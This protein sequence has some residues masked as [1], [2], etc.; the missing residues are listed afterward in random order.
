MDWVG[1]TNPLAPL[2]PQYN[3][4]EFLFWGYVKDQILCPKVGV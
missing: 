1:Q 4:I 3:P 2:L